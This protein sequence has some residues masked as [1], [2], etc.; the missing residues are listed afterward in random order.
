V[1]PI[2]VLLYHIVDDDNPSNIAITV[3]QFKQHLAVISD[4]GYR[5]ATLDEFIASL[6]NHRLTDQRSVLLTFD[7]GYEVVL[8][9]AATEMLRFGF[10][11]TVFLVAGYMGEINWWNRKAKYLQRHLSWEQARELLEMGWDLGAHTMEHQSLVKLA[12]D[13]IEQEMVSSKTAIEHELGIAVSSFAYPYGDVNDLVE[14]IAS[15]H[16]EVA[17]AT[18]EE[19]T[20][21]YQ[22]HRIHRLS[23]DR[24]WRGAELREALQGRLG[25]SP[26]MRARLT[27]RGEELGL[28]R[29]SVYL[30][31]AGMERVGRRIKRLVEPP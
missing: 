9:K 30:L 14:E 26:S 1:T 2:P 20:G 13:T 24:Y 7:D 12:P 15:R 27:R 17:F 4:L 19:F 10:H 16:F 23:P 21:R 25:S 31:G 22:P 8:T 11:A 5:T 6:N 18:D 29:L 28:A 3:S